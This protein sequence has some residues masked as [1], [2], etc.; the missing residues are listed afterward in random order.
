MNVRCEHPPGSQTLLI[1]CGLAPICSAVPHSAVIFFSSLRLHESRQGSTFSAEDV[2]LPAKCK[3][4]LRP[5]RGLPP[6]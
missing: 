4:A 2:L 5:R 3:T 1:A 6:L